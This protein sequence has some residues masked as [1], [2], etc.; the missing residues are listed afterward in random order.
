MNAGMERRGWGWGGGG[1][2]GVKR[3]KEGNLASN[4]RSARAQIFPTSLSKNT[5]PNPP[6]HP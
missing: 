1:G 5:I 4:R 6:I 2:V 3:G